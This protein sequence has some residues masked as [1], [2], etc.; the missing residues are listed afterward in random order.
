MHTSEVRKAE[1]LSKRIVFPPIVE[2][3]IPREGVSPKASEIFATSAII[4]KVECVSSDQEVHALK[5]DS[6]EELMNETKPLFFDTESLNGFDGL[7]LAPGYPETKSNVLMVAPAADEPAEEP[8]LEN[9][10]E[11]FFKSQKFQDTREVACEESLQT[12]EQESDKSQRANDNSSNEDPFMTSAAKMDSHEDEIMIEERDQID[13][14]YLARG[15]KN[16]DQ[17]LSELDQMIVAEDSPVATTILEIQSKIKSGL[18]QHEHVY[19]CT[20]T[21]PFEASSSEKSKDENTATVPH[22]LEFDLKT[23]NEIL[24]DQTTE[25]LSV[26]AL[27]AATVSPK[28]RKCVAVSITQKKNGAR[29]NSLILPFCFQP[30]SKFSARSPIKEAD[31]DKRLKT[32]SNMQLS[33]IKSAPSSAYASNNARNEVHLSTKLVTNGRVSLSEA[34]PQSGETSSVTCHLQP[35]SECYEGEIT[36]DSKK[37]VNL[38]VSEDSNAVLKTHKS[39]QASLPEMD[40]VKR[41]S[42][43]LLTIYG[44]EA[45]G[46]LPLLMDVKF[47][48]SFDQ[49]LQCNAVDDMDM[50]K[51]G[52]SRTASSEINKKL[53]AHCEATKMELQRHIHYIN[54]HEEINDFPYATMQ[55]YQ[56]AKTPLR[57]N[58]V[59]AMKRD[60]LPRVDDGPQLA[61]SMSIDL[62]VESAKLGPAPL[63]SVSATLHSESLQP[64]NF[65]NYQLASAAESL[66]AVLPDDED[67]TVELMY[68]TATNS[69][70]DPATGKYYE[71]EGSDEDVQIGIQ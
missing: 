40:T 63:T 67:E 47:D 39:G 26:R 5:S 54:E 4:E 25:S 15:V 62:T 69:Y 43:L 52:Q 9:E 14:E 30:G 7:D 64:G 68:D 29:R 34:K 41:S 60:A 65:T 57:I 23:S 58:D 38:T 19:I 6:E 70:Y 37:Q 49:A 8:K 53:T 45:H 21:A 33:Q 48:D 13:G 31:E 28:Q 66:T 46:I 16:M 22:E 35:R 50:P 36:K 3:R 32:L 10:I 20:E 12:S 59:L 42:E 18:Q 71:I 44:E 1:T 17:I 56:E 51:V 11:A 55:E 2:F 27:L 24:H 61:A